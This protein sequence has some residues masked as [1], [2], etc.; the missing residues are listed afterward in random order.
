[1]KKRKSTKPA[2]T[3]LSSLFGK[4]G[5]LRD[6]KKLSS[7]DDL[8]ILFSP[9]DD[10]HKPKDFASFFAKTLHTDSLQVAIKEKS[11]HPTTN[12]PSATSLKRWPSPQNE[13]DLHGYTASEAEDKTVFFI[14]QAKNNRLKTVR[15][16]TG[17]GLHS[18][19]GPVLKTVVE[20]KLVEFKG[21]KKII[22][23]RWEKKTKQ[24]SGAL[25]VY[26]N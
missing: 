4:K 6:I 8:E 20:A 2:L 5:E 14:T 10:H 1:M 12:P 3:S 7:T 23:Y 13:L 18:P 17:K 11:T 15:I 19:Q 21:Q 25:I 26:L 22:T 9:Q 16:I 24:K